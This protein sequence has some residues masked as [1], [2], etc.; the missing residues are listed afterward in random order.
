MS[1]SSEKLCPQKKGDSVRLNSSC[2]HCG[3]QVF[4]SH[5]KLVWPNYPEF[6]KSRTAHRKCSKVKPRQWRFAWNLI[7]QLF[8]Q[9][10][11]AK[12]LS[13]STDNAIHCLS[14]Q[15]CSLVL[16]RFKDCSSLERR[17]QEKPKSNWRN[18][19]NLHV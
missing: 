16:S 6:S 17:L 9:T 10:L 5:P 15:L 13:L 1:F 11:G 3:G 12:K 19:R 8:K 2:Q 4:W 14:A 18:V 7:L